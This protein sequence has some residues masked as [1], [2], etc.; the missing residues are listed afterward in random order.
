[1]TDNGSTDVLLFADWIAAETGIYEILYETVIRTRDGI[2]PR[3]K[4]LLV[5][6]WDG[7]NDSCFQLIHF[8]EP[9]LHEHLR[10]SQAAN[11]CDRSIEQSSGHSHR[12]STVYNGI[13]FLCTSG[14]KDML[15]SR[16]NIQP[17]IV[18]RPIILR[19]GCFA[20]TVIETVDCISS[21]EKI[22]DKINR[23]S[24]KLEDL[25]IDRCARDE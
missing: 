8:G 21:I 15:S 24:W 13:N 11:P 16:G 6:R 25:I 9:R 3:P 22:T 10:C 19:S 18:G 2:K 4:Y 20:N 7:R 5:Y 1:M 23:Y 14:S 17:S 12:S